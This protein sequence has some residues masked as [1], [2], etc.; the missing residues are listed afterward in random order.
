MHAQSLRDQAEHR[1]R[2]EALAA[3]CFAYQNNGACLRNCEADGFDQQR[4]F[5]IPY[6]EI[7]NS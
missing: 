4:A 2:D 3:T 5:L 1:L 6:R 7:T